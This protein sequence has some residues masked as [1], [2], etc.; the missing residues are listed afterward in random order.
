MAEIYTTPLDDI[1]K[2]NK[3]ALVKLII[4]ARSAQATTLKTVLCASDD[5]RTQSSSLQQLQSAI[6]PLLDQLQQGIQLKL[7]ELHDQLR[8]MQASAISPSRQAVVHNVDSSESADRNESSSSEDWFTVPLRSFSSVVHRSVQA[9][10]KDDRCRQDVISGSTSNDDEKFTKDLLK[11]IHINTMPVSHKRIGKEGN[12]PRL[13]HLTFTSAPDAK[14]FMSSYD[15]ARKNKCDGLPSI[16]LRSGKTKEELVTFR[17]SASAAHELNEEAKADK[18]TSFSFRD[19]VH[20]WKFRNQEDGN[21]KRDPITPTTSSP[22]DIATLG[23]GLAKVRFAKQ[24]YSGTYLI[25]PPPTSVP[26]P[27]PMH[28]PGHLIASG[29]YLNARSLKH[30][31]SSVNKLVELQNLV[32]SNRTIFVAITETWLNDS[33]F[34]GKVLPPHF[35]IHHK[36]S[37]AFDCI[38]HDPL[39]YKLNHFYGIDSCLL[40][41]FKD[42]L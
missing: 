38:S 8:E 4:E 27:A 2:M 23:V 24:Q 18:T 33:V 28:Q 29:I 34:V 31:T 19:S 35:F 42:Y 14:T 32:A 40:A 20:I 16:R 41:W 26:P 25:D 1:K 22:A 17:K 3:G 12:R 9:A 39:L 15:Y 11:L 21:W 6:G 13:L 10:L 5:R 37:K 7:S 36:D 30:V